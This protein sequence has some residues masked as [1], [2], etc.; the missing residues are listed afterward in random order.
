MT[1]SPNFY[2]SEIGVTDLPIFVFTLPD[3]REIGSNKSADSKISGSG[4]TA[5][6]LHFF[7]LNLT[8]FANYVNQNNFNNVKV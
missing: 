7:K 5:L 8:F 4:T 1:D 2:N 6:V 3:F